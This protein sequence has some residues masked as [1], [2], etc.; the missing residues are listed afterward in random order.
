MK[1]NSLPKVTAEEKKSLFRDLESIFEDGDN[2]VII[3]GLDQEG[4]AL[5]FFHASAMDAILGF[6]I[7]IAEM[8]A[9][10][11]LEVNEIIDKIREVAESAKGLLGDTQKGGRA[12]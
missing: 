8:T 9:H 3:V 12:S 5:R 1:K 2:A 6:G 7:M 11:D 4:G 10:G